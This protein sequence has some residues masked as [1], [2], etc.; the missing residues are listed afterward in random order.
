[1]TYKSSFVDSLVLLPN[2]LIFPYALN[3]SVFT[4][5]RARAMVPATPVKSLAFGVWLLFCAAHFFPSQN[6]QFISDK[7]R[8]LNLETTKHFGKSRT[9][10]AHSGVVIA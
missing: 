2:S 8:T 9:I 10:V 6:K 7:R 1:V 3:L 4:T 5:D